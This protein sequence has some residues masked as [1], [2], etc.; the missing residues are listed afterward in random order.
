MSMQPDMTDLDVDEQMRKAQRR[1]RMKK[2]WLG[3]ID[4]REQAAFVIKVATNGFYVLAAFQAIV[5][6]FLFGWLAIIDAGLF[7]LFAFLTARFKSCIAAVVLFVLSMIAFIST[8]LNILMDSGG[9]VNFL[10][11]VLMSILS[12]RALQAAFV[13]QKLKNQMS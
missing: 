4:S 8:I 7:A 10:L 5:G 2:F 11:T 1:A 13:Y 6:V 9:G 12:L 3:K